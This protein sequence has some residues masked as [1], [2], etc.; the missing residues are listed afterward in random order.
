M[1]SSIVTSPSAK[2][3]GSP[4]SH[5]A[6][7]DHGRAVHVARALR[8]NERDDVGGFGKRADAAHRAVAHVLLAAR[9]WQVVAHA[10]I[11][12]TGGDAVHGDAV[13]ADL[14]RERF[15]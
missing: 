14:L 3:A 9:R 13:A 11:E 12:D 10:R 5:R 15:G 2:P 6:I 7:D 8:S 1:P 4:S